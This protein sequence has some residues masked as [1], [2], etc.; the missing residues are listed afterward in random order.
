M[1][2][3]QASADATT[4]L[5]VTSLGKGSITFRNHGPNTVWIGPAGV[6]ISTG[7]ELAINETILADVDTGEVIHAVCDTAETADLSWVLS[8][9]Y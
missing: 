4:A 9:Q 5:L 1:N 7:F 8:S 3:G 2:V 6:S